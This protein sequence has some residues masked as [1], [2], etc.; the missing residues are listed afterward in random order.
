MENDHER[1]STE[2]EA[3]PVYAVGKH[4]R[5]GVREDSHSEDDGSMIPAR[6]VDPV[7]ARI[8]S[9]KAI[10]DTELPIALSES[11]TNHRR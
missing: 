1:R 5:R 10:V 11:P 3:S 4:P 8:S 6:L 7:T 9:G 2:D